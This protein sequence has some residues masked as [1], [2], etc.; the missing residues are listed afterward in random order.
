MAA[1]LTLDAPA[2]LLRS[3]CGRTIPLHVWRWLG[4]AEPEEHDLLDRALGPVLDVGCG[5]GRHLVALALRGV[6]ALGIDIAPSA[7]ALARARGAQVL[8]RSVFDRLPGD[9]LWGS[10]L[11]LDGNIGIGGDPAALLVRLR[12]LL[13]HDGRVLVELEPPGGPTS[14]LLVRVEDGGD[15]S[16]WFDWAQLASHD[17]DGVARD[18]GFEVGERWHAGGRWFARLDASG[19]E[20]RSGVGDVA[21]ARGGDAA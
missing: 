19:A 2:T 21:A 6:P 10:A 11:L 4:D 16:H 9:G 7:V 8:H 15:S 13:R 18:A 1:R 17:V 3:S 14:T 5:P 20:D 12:A